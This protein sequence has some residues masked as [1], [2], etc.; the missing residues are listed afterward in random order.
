MIKLQRHPKP[1]ELTDDLQKH[2]TDEFKLTGKP[3]W[4]VEFIKRT[5]LSLS[6]KKCCYCESSIVEESKYMEVEHF[7][8]KS[9]YPDLVMKWDNLLPACKK[10][11]ASKRDHD[12]KKEPIIDPTKDTPKIHL[13]LH[14]FRVRGIDA[15]GKMTVSVLNLNDQ[16]RLVQKRFAI[17]N[18]VQERIENLNELVGE[19][20]SE[21]H[22]NTKRENRIVHGI[23]ALLK[24]GLPT[25]VYSATVATIILTYGEYQELKEKL[26]SLNLWDDD[27]VEL[28]E[29][30][31]ALAL[32]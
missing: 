20:C 14:N 19:H 15:L 23:K 5:L 25:S 9:K 22:T 28:E 31:Q 8:P 7:Y 2:L 10:C 12:T 18:A 26:M 27:M 32:Y 17:G 1:V 30:V 4:N 3:V 11:N 24:E 16:D 13:R 6:H 21:G 29:S